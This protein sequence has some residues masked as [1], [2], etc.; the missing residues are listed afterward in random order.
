MNATILL[1][2]VTASGLL[3]AQDPQRPQGPPPMPPVQKILDADGDGK[4]SASEIAKASEVLSE[5]DLDGNGRL[6]KEETRP[7]RPDEGGEEKRR[8]RRERQEEGGR[9]V[10]PIMEALDQNGDGTISQRELKRA[11][12]SLLELDQDENGSLESEEMKPEPPE[13]GEAQEGGRGGRPY[14]PHPPRRR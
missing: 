4:L 5:L 12:K 7:P 11:A 2:F 8:P 14:P 1:M 13:E 9:P 6:S 10:R 3:C